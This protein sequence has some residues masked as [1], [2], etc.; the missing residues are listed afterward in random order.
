[1]Q[2]GARFVRLRLFVV[3]VLLAALAP[4]LPVVAQDV[5][6]DFGVFLPV[7]AAGAEVVG[8]AARTLA[9]DPFVVRARRV[10]I[11]FE[12][13]APLTD[14]LE[15]GAAFPVLR[16]NLF[17]NVVVE[18]LVESVDLTASG[19]SW[20][21]GVAGDPMGSVAVA[22]NGDVVSGVV[23]TRGREYMIRS[24]G[25][26]QY[27][28]REVDRSGLPE[29][30]P[31]LVPRLLDADPAPAAFVDD[32]GRVDIAVFY[33]SEAQEDAGGTDEINA[34][35]DVWVADTNGAYL[36]S[37]I[38]HRLNL[39]LREQVSY[40]E[41]EDSEDNSVVK[42]AIDCLIE[43]DDDCLDAVHA[44]REKY[45]ADLVHLIVGGPSP[46]SA[47]GRASLT[48]SFGVS[49]LVCGS[50]TF[51]HEIGHNS[52]VNHDRYVEYDEECDT[53]A[54]T[55]CFDDFPSAYAYGYV[56]Q[57]GL[58]SGA[59]Y[60]HR[61]RTVMAYGKQCSEAEVSCPTLMRFSTPE[62]SWYGD[63]LGVSGTTSRSSYSDA[64]EAAR[65]GPAD[66]ARTHREFAHDLA[67]RVVRKA[68]DLVVKGL[69]ANQLQAV[70]GAL[71]RLSAVVENLGILTGYAPETAVTWCRASASGCS[72]SV[73]VPSSVPYLE[74]NGRAPV[75]T[76]FA[77]PSAQGSYSYRACVSSSPG[78]TLTENNC[79][80]TV[81][82]EVG[83]VDLQFSMSLSTYSALAGAEVTIEGVAHNRGT[84]PAHA[85]QMHF[86]TLDS[87]SELDWFGLHFFQ[88][89]AAGS[90]ATFETTF[91]APSVAGD[92]PYAACLASSHVEFTC[93]E[94]NLSV[95]SSSTPAPTQTP[96]PTPT[97]SVDYEIVDVRR[98]LSSINTADWL[99]FTWRAR[100]P[101]QRFEV[102]VRFQQ[103]AFFSSCTELWFNPTVGQ[104]V[105]ETTIPSVC[106]TDEQWSS[107]TIQPADGRMCDGCGTFARE[108]LPIDPSLLTLESA[109]PAEIPTFIEELDAAR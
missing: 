86:V 18:S 59:L 45:S 103:G 29:G 71:V 106:G 43:D 16:L 24:V 87:A 34:L 90:S 55:P 4:A 64:A 7:D 39:V 37:D 15:R 10:S 22:V 9:G 36:R 5:P 84:L 11:D 2:F 50:D 32:P 60:E 97:P 41:G 85:S 46:E 72:S 94:E 12:V 23:R 53:D 104:Q 47:C 92:Y 35:I 67:N 49:H 52:G 38:Q 69:Q 31:P 93:L 44:R 28:I 27:S 61:W 102:T 68:P 25:S 62:Q 99:K 83:V 63:A 26:G 98:Y 78:E 21:G 1:M 95:V 66:A 56:N 77:L 40:T 14:V 101:A 33:T 76:S 13:F 79:S 3:L 6:G 65:I 91:E 109:D 89:I 30:A 82:V 20:S 54:E 19:Y 74:S 100:T 108:T 17:E 58:N 96:T 57:L 80:E 70:P 107:V 81:T 42:Q 48:G 8:L 73:G 105:V 51:V 75:S 88:T